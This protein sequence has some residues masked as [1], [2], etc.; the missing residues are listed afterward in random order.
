MG[1]A[2]RNDRG[3]KAG[4]GRISHLA[5]ALVRTEWRVMLLLLLLL[6]VLLILGRELMWRWELVIRVLRIVAVGRV[7]VVVLLLLLLVLVLQQHE[8]LLCLHEAACTRI[9][10][11]HDLAVDN[12]HHRAVWER[13]RE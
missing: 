13:E 3:L 6:I 2:G 5:L 12:L 1:G 7:R 11:V 9:V 10:V 8:V 4:H